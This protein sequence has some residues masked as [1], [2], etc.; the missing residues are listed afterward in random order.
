MVFVVL[1][2]WRLVCW[3]FNKPQTQR[4][5]NDLDMYFVVFTFDGG[6]GSQ[7]LEP[8]L[9]TLDE[10]HVQGTFFLTG[11]WK[12]SEGYTAQESKDRI[13]SNLTPGSIYLMHIGDTITGAILDDVFTEIEAQGY[14]IVSISEALRS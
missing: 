11:S 2:Y 12:E 3:R 14:R 6:S 1:S 10:Y 4:A 9:Q 13:L 7:S 8:I 5:Y